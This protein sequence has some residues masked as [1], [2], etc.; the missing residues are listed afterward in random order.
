MATNYRNPYRRGTEEYK[1]RNAWIKSRTKTD[2]TARAKKAISNVGNATFA[3]YEL[4]EKE[5]TKLHNA[6]YTR[7][8][9]LRTRF[10]SEQKKIIDSYAQPAV[11]RRR[12]TKKITID[13]FYTQNSGEQI[14]N[15]GSFEITQRSNESVYEAKMRHVVEVIGRKKKIIEKGEYTPT[16]N[17]LSA[18]MHQLELLAPNQIHAT[19]IMDLTTWDLSDYKNL[20]YSNPMIK[21]VIDKLVGLTSMSEAGRNAQKKRQG[22]LWAN[23]AGL[24]EMSADLIDKYLNSSLFMRRHF[25]PIRYKTDSKN[26]MADEIKTIEE[27]GNNEAKEEIRDILAA[28]E[29]AIK[30]TTD[31]ARTEEKYQKKLDKAIEKAIRG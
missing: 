16:G 18:Y 29:I 11:A 13:T 17:T 31:R 5:S 2:Y 4:S 9:E 26:I 30:R 28:Y 22:R 8:G 27:S 21:L 23:T 24:T 10:T 12:A 15:A 20:N 25:S 6:L 14:V 1:K 7:N 3:G 19:R